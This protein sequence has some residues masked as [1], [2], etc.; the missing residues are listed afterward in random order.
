MFIVH[1]NDEEQ[2]K[3]ENITEL[4]SG[5]TPPTTGIVKR[6]YAK[7]RKHTPFPVRFRMISYIQMNNL[8]WSTQ[9]RKRMLLV[10]KMI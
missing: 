1:E 4:S 8:L 9:Y 2:K 10:L 5:I 7:T 6:K 3:Y